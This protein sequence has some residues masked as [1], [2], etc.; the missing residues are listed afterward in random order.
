[1][2]AEFK[3]GRLRFTWNGIWA[4]STFYNRD[5]VVNYN[6]KTYVCV[7]PNTSSSN[8]YND[9]NAVPYSYWNLVVDGKKWIGA[10]ITSTFYSVGNVVTFGG[11]AY[12]CTLAHTSTAFALDS[13]NWA[14]YSEFAT[15][16][17]DWTT[18]KTYG[19]NDVVKYGGIVYKCIANHTSAVSSASGLE[20]NQS[21]WTI[22]FNGLEYKGIWTGASFRYKA[23]DLVKNGPDLWISL[24]GHTSTTLFDQTKWA[25]WLPGQEYAGIWSAS[26]TYQPGD[27]VEYGGYEY[28]SQTANNINN[29]PSI[30]AVDWKLLN[31]S[32]NW[33]SSWNVGSAYLVGDTITRNGVTYTAIAD[34]TA[35]DPAAFTTNTTYTA[36]GSSGTTLKVASTTG[37]VIGMN[38]IGVGFN[39][40]QTVSTVVDSTTLTISAAPANTIVDAQA[41]SFVGVNYVYWNILLPGTYWRK[42]WTNVVTY[43]VG[44]LVVWQN[45]T[46]V[47]IQSHTSTVNVSGVVATGNRPDVDTT[48]TYWAPYIAH[49]AKNAMNTYGDIETYGSTSLLG[50]VI[51]TG[52]KAIPIG[53]EQYMLRN[54]AGTPT[55]TKV[56]VIPAVYYVSNSTGIDRS[57]Y[58]TTWDQPWKTIRYA[59]DTVGAGTQN[60]YA[61]SN[62]TKN[63]LWITTEMIQWT[64]YQIANS[65]SGFTPAYQLNQTKA[66]RDAG[67]IIDAVAYDIARGGNSQTVAATLAYFVFGSTNTFF[68][69]DVAA[70]MPYYLP[71]LNR[72]AVL[73]N[74]AVTTT[75]L[76]QSYQTASIATASAGTISGFTFTASGTV[77]GTFA[78]GMILSGTGIAAGTYL[79]S[80]SGTTWTV[81]TYQT[82][83][84]TS[85]SGITAVIP[86]TVGST[87]ENLSPAAVQS[88]LS[89]ITTALT[90]QS[91]ALVPVPNTGVQATI[92]V[93]TGTYGETLPIVIPPNVAIVGDELRSVVVKPAV[94]IS[95]T[96]TATSSADNTVTITSTTG[97]VDQMPVQFVDPSIY[98]TFTYVSPFASI[99]AGKTYYVVGS[100]ITATKFSITGSNGTYN[101]ITSVT[102]TGTGV[103][104]EFT[105]SPTSTGSYNVSLY[106]GGS[107]YTV[108][109]SIKILGTSIGGVTPGNDI[110]LTILQVSS[111]AITAFN[112]ISGSS[113][114]PM[115]TVTGS[116]TMYAGDCLKD[117]FR[118]RN[119]SGL[120]NATLIGLQGSLG[121]P[122]ANFIQRPTGGSY[123]CFDPGTG[124]NDTTAWIYRRSP[125]VQ[126]V[127]SFG[128]GCTALKIDG[129]LHNGGAKTIVANDFTHIINDGVGVYCTGP[130]ALTEVIS[131]FSYYG[132]TGYFAEDGGR[133]RA[134]NGNTSYGTYGVI[135]SGYD[136]TEAPAT[137]IVFNQSSQVQ[138]TVQSAFGTTSQL[139]RINYSNAGSSYSTTTTNMLYYTNNFIGANWATDSNVSF[140]KV[141][142][143]PTGLVE[144]W[145]MTGTSGVAG[146]SYVYQNISVPPPGATYTNISAVNVSGSG[147]AATFDITV[148]STAYVVVVNNPG[149][150]YAVT[151]QLYIAGS[152][153]GGVNNVNDCVLTITGLAG[154]TITAVS[155]SGV[156][157]INSALNYTFSVYVKQGTATSIDLYGIFSGTSTMTSAI[158][159]NFV[160]NTITASSS[161]SYT[162]GST[163]INSFTPINYGAINQQLSTTSPT[164]GWYRLWFTLNDSLGL[165]NNLQFR[166]YPK[167][168]SGSANAYTFVYGSQAE[169]SKSNYVPSFYLENVTNTRYT[170]YANFNISGA[171]TGVV[172]V[173]DEIR[174]GSIFQTRV[175]NDSFGFSGGAGYLTSSNNAQSGADQ[176]IQLSQ[177]DA[178][179]NANYTGMR[180][181]I[182]SGAGAGQYGYISYFN[183]SNK[184]AYILKESFTPLSIASTDSGT[185]Q[186]TLS[187][188]TNT[189]LYVGQPVQFIPTY[190]TT[191][192]TSTSLA[193]TTVTASVGGTT[194]TLTV[195]S[196][197]GLAVNT[198]VTFT[199]TGVGQTLFTSV[200]S[201]YNY[202]IYAIL[203]STTIQITSTIFGNVWQLNS[204]TG[205]M[206]MNFSS[207]TRYLQASTTN[208]V[209]NLP[210]QFTGTAL[211]GLS[212]G[213]QYYIKDIIDSNNFSISGS[214]VTIT[215]TATNASNGQLTVTSTAA[216]IP[217]SPIIF[218]TPTIGTFVDGTKYYISSIVNSTTFTVASTLLSSTA[219]ATTAV[220]NLV[221]VPSTTGYV[222]NQPI[223]FVG[224]TF[225]GI[226]AE[227]VYYILAINNATTFTVS[228]TPGGAAVT[229]STASGLMTARTCPT[230][231]VPTSASGGSMIGTTTGAK[232]AVTLSIGTMTGTF[233]TNLFGNVVLGTTYY[234]N[235]IPSTTV[236]TITATKGSGTAFAL[237]TKTG[238]MNIAEVGWDHLNLGTT[239]AIAFDA[240][241]VYYIE[242]RVIYS[243]PPFIQSSSIVPSLAIGSYWTAVA[244]GNNYW[245]ALPSSNSTGAYSTD[246]LTWLSMALPSSQSWSAIAFGNGYWVA[247]A[248]ASTV[249]AVSKS[250]GQGWTTYSLPSTSA[251]SYVA[252]GNGVFVTVASGQISNTNVAAYS[253]DF[254]RTWTAS[255]LPAS[256]N[257]VSLTYGNGIFV[258]ISGGNNTAAAYSTNGG[259]TWTSSTL[260][261]AYYTCVAFGNNQFVAVSQVGTASYTAYS[262]DGKT[263]TQSNVQLLGNYMAYGNGVFLVVPG[264]G[265]ATAYTSEG[266][267]IWKQQTVSNIEYRCIAFG[268][269]ASGSGIFVTLG[270]VATGTTISTGATTKARP[271]I[272][273]NTI[274]ALNEWEAGGGYTS[275]PTVTFTDP[276]V[277]LL[278]VVSPRIGNG[279]LGSPSFVSRG[280]GYS[281]SST[282]SIVTGNGYADAY[283]TGLTIILNNLTRIPQPGDNLTISGISQV[284][285][286][287]SA[288]AVFNTV[289][290]NLEANV[291]VS[292]SIT[293]ATS[294]AN[295]TAVSI[296]SKYSQARLSNHDFLNIGYGDQAA[297]NYPGYPS[298]G[299]ASLPQNQVIEVNYG[300]VFFT[301]TDQDGNFKVGNLF[302]VQQ[303]TGIITL[304]ASQFGL[305]GLSSLSLGGISVGGSSVVITQF[306]TDATFTANSD[307]LLPTQKSIKSYI[308]SRLS[309]GGANT[310][311][312]QLIAG[313]VVVGGPNFISSA[314]PNGTAGSVVRVGTNGTT[315]NKVYIAGP[316][317][318]SPPT[319][320]LF[321]SY[322]GGGVD[323]SM[324]AYHFFIRHSSK[325]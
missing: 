144:A 120:R 256:T 180:L 67:Y 149:S 218:S 268:L 66:V 61:A 52:R 62:I 190:Y 322:G 32:F 261:N 133:I 311:T 47:C 50:N 170:G 207:N 291:S 208:M 96:A 6:G 113:I 159:Y 58:G 247:V 212:N 77:T 193:Q 167:G 44:D 48:N 155:V 132:Y 111:G 187:S 194:N 137:G 306:S 292:P 145:T 151:N 97:L 102:V 35:Q 68:N 222:S 171:G 90:S 49:S 115:T 248:S 40:G 98:T 259:Q 146:N 225:G 181:F 309:Q 45:K 192:I 226:T 325:K 284:F 70:D 15:W 272:T 252:Y 99:T 177:S 271:T 83:S 206:T 168:Y 127:T 122:D 93:K 314:V 142:Q 118:M 143:A 227:T 224:N 286:V 267:G 54:T 186:F 174:T 324:V 148:T 165:N 179:T 257:W 264:S 27:T 42:F 209:V 233:S 112:F 196:T 228:A 221:T 229:L 319:L 39:Q 231:V 312:G 92:Y 198:L 37:I 251:W 19:V 78:V 237:S 34:N 72:L 195:A 182:I 79:V 321:G 55:W 71:M 75:P 84:S 41:L 161:G 22:L 116:M 1:M 26:T 173:A 242:P 164:A 163:V 95:T 285:K 234:I 106:S 191:S 141:N 258:A 9:L 157:P 246:G 223:V 2:A 293:T 123:A 80:G 121:A 287:T 16:N 250:N 63:K 135:S 30:D 94:A 107:G 279:V 160:T 172:T 295:G 74:N 274:T 276:N 139:L 150:G 184:Y 7:V 201:N 89:I 305:S 307:S 53:T 316:A 294:T 25:L 11:K 12:Y 69:A 281:T 114:I 275:T 197:V 302:G 158:S 220:S 154:S 298:A 82:V 255:T 64:L 140:S 297:S 216:L 254:G 153:F 129:N 131:V 188:G 262:L 176:Y 245:L 119:G 31:A 323:G 288:Y 299:Y 28:V 199:A 14:V 81:N 232:T 189:T 253:T 156:V 88:L 266:G 304:S 241:T 175:I 59:C 260:P 310:F 46:Y 147:S 265:S 235:T 244:Y 162:I 124:P 138:A 214:L 249:V 203:N 86:F 13:S 4:P 169:L 273:S 38:I 128:N 313:S 277:T 317:G 125:Y 185:N 320:P 210:M 109:T 183:A 308:T 289:A 87:P 56:L 219:T 166:I 213:V 10:W 60:V 278:A 104:A 108:G 211:G 236:F 20:A 126:N 51:Y 318:N 3:I 238:A 23:N 100:T 202:Y 21:A 290:P 239:P 243:A 29:I 105:V 130:G 110:Q 36:T 269:T 91:T 57:D 17:S 136:L 205:S 204:G 263:W 5:A 283:Q 200:Q 282:L 178:N 76:S 240:S 152:T 18:G 103:G 8:F 73:I 215:V 230:Y 280:L 33:R 43:T 270:G 303:A 301:S 296:R 315:T 65:L 300:R 217:L 134:A 24:S 117:M 101:L 85:I